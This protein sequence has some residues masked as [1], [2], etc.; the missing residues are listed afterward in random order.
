MVPASSHSRVGNYVGRKFWFL[1]T[2]SNYVVA[3]TV[4]LYSVCL[5]AEEVAVCFLTVPLISPTNV[6]RIRPQ[7]GL[8]AR[9]PQLMR[10]V[11]KAQERLRQVTDGARGLLRMGVANGACR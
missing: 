1:H 11:A 4:C 6:T 2:T 10:I 8:V 7:C 9:R 3:D 5:K